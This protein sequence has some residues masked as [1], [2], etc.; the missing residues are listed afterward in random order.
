M[1][2]FAFAFLS[3]SISAKATL[4]P[5]LT[6]LVAGL[7]V[8]KHVASLRTKVVV[9]ATVCSI[10]HERILDATRTSIY[11]PD[12]TLSLPIVLAT[13]VAFAGLF[14][15][16]L[17]AKG[18]LSSSSSSHSLHSDAHG[19]DNNGDDPDDATADEKIGPYDVRDSNRAAGGQG[20]P[21][22]PSP[23]AETA[24]HPKGR[25]WLAWI[26][27]ALLVVGAALGYLYRHDIT[28]FI[29]HNL[30]FLC[31]AD[32]RK[33]W[34]Y[35]RGA[36][37]IVYALSYFVPTAIVEVI[38]GC[39]IDLLCDG[40]PIWISIPC[41][42]LSL[43][44]TATGVYFIATRVLYWACFAVYWSFG[45]FNKVARPIFGA[46]THS[47]CMVPW[48][49]V[50]LF[51]IDI[52]FFFYKISVRYWPC[53]LWLAKNVPSMFWFAELETAQNIAIISV[54]S[55]VFIYRTFA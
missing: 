47:I 35:T 45:I 10:E 1:S 25:N 17:G 53:A 42:V 55:A 14:V 22:D 20:P 51:Y 41:V 32:E 31:N 49:G 34:M 29:K 36:Q 11:Q 15:G 40:L 24:P 37:V 12:A 30:L 8:A 19:N 4:H 26:L 38:A 52:A 27:L 23:G 39:V 44:S 46:F 9:S 48:V 7:Q 5:I 18:F 43:Y 33:R 21:P 3:S 16:I 54:P 50:A 2:S 13:T 28:T 6:S